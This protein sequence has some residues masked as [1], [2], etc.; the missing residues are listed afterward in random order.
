M[1]LPVWISILVSQR[2]FKFYYGFLWVALIGVGFKHYRFN[3]HDYEIYKTAGE[4]ILLGRGLD[5]YD[6][7]RVEPGGF[8]YPY[9][10][11]LVFGLFL[12]MSLGWDKLLFLGA[13]LGSYFFILKYSVEWILKAF[14]L[15]NIVYY[16]V[17]TW[18]LLANIYSFNDALINSNIG[19][20]L[21]FFS[22]IALK[23]EE[24]SPF[25]AGFFLA[26]GSALKL[27]PLL[28]LGYWGWKR[29]FK[30]IFYG[31]GFFL[32]FYFLIPLL[33]EGVEGGINLLRNHAIVM[34]QY[35]EQR[36]WNYSVV[37]FQNFSG[38]LLRYLSLVGLPEKV[39]L[40]WVFGSLFLGLVLS[41]LPGFLRRDYKNSQNNLLIAIQTLALVS[42]LAPVSWY[43]MGVFYVPLI[44]LH[45]IMA[46]YFKSQTSRIVLGIYVLLYC[47]TSSDIWGRTLNDA[48]EFFSLPFFGVLSLLMGLRFYIHEQVIKFSDA[49]IRRTVKDYFE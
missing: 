8:Y 16:P 6:V 42:L 49:R 10:W 35:G 5:L 40:P 38:F 21:M 26:F 34:S 18:V 31:L 19:I 29:N 2:A 30:A 22:I 12:K 43:N 37:V 36:G 41:Y 7:T 3:F 24:K 1:S 20:L 9:F 33:F 4:K 23:F 48:M 13:F 27:Y 39:I 46:I 28:L 45:V 11:A 25:W 17:A 15:K 47:L 14:H 32:I 44:S